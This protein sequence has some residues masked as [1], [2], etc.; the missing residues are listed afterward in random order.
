MDNIKIKDVSVPFFD[1]VCVF[2]ECQKCCL[3]LEQLIREDE[4][5]AKK[6][7][8]KRA[9]QYGWKVKDGDVFCEKCAKNLK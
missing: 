4:E 7:L 3:S 6:K 5:Q 1:A 8:V 9:N 2:V